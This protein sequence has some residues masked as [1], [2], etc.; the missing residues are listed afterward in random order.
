MRSVCELCEFNNPKASATAVIIRDGKILLLKRA[1]EPFKNMW[2]LPGGYAHYMEQPEQVLARELKE[3]LGVR[4]ALTF[5]AAVPGTAHWKG[6][7]FAI[8]SF[9]YLADIGH[10]K[11]KL[12]AENSAFL[13]QPIKDL[14]P[15]AIAFDSNRTIGSLVKQKF[16]FDLGRVRDLVRQLDP[17]AAVKEHSLYRAVLNGFVATTFDGGKLV[18]MGWIFPRQTAL[19]KQAVIEDM[20]IDESYRGR[21][22]G[23]KLM[24]ELTVWAGKNG[25]EVIELTSSPKRIAANGLYKKCQFVLHPT[26]HYLYKVKSRRAR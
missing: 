13:W 12:N 5:V 4:A 2:D 16:Y 20:I 17:S 10:Q 22:L 23:K 6:K 9:C 26:N 25:V 15:K 1:E 7:E 14:N 8:I 21:G 11:I 3:E 24:D 19:R 18:G